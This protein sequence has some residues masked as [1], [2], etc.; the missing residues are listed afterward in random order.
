LYCHSY[1]LPSSLTLCAG[2]AQISSLPFALL[3]LHRSNHFSLLFPS[4]LQSFPSRAS[5]LMDMKDHKR[6]TERV[7]QRATLLRTLT[8][9]LDGKLS[10]A[11]F[12]KMKRDAVAVNVPAEANGEGDEAKDQDQPFKLLTDEV[13][14]A[15]KSVRHTR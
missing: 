3:G 14:A 5:V 15:E 4:T 1:S 2:L 9:V 13:L 8:S 11:D 10:F 12:V 7:A 6:R